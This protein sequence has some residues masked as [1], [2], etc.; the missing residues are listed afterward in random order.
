ML[1]PLALGEI[2]TFESIQTNEVANA[3]DKTG[4]NKTNN[5]IVAG[6]MQR[7]FPRCNGWICRAVICPTLMPCKD[8]LASYFAYWSF[9]PENVLVALRLGSCKDAK[10]EG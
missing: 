7:F 9:F 5:C 6:V 10:G 8:F 3:Q 2:V 1:R 4:S